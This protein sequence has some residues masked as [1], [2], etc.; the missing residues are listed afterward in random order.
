[1]LLC[2]PSS[3]TLPS[4]SAHRRLRV[5][6]HAGLFEVLRAELCDEVWAVVEDG[7]LGRCPRDRPSVSCGLSTEICEGGTLK[8]RSPGRAAALEVMSP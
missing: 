6:L 3:P 4:S 5:V 8:T 2:E 7:L 1:M